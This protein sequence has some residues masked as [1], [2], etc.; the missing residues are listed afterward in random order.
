MTITIYGDFTC[1]FSYLASRRVDLLTSHGVDVEWRAVEH[2]PRTPLTGLQLSEE[3]AQ[4]M[5]EEWQS[6]ESLLLPGET[7]P[8]RAPAMLASTQAAVAAYA[9]AVGAGVS[10][11][12]RDLLF[13]AYWVDGKDI[14]HPEV[15]R[16][17]LST[18]FR[19]GTSSSHPLHEFG[20]AV[21]PA[22]GPVTSGAYHRI[23]GWRSDWAELGDATIPAMQ[24]SGVTLTGV[25]ALRR[26][27]ELIADH[28]GETVA[29]PVLELPEP[30]GRFWI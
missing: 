17:L 20:Y 26:L 6:V 14:G 1:P 9:E 21:T 3:Q 27:G 10:G 30:S 23:A 2:A 24:R 13:T 25:P 18:P 22:R 11:I 12:V 28:A 29:E 16:T 4:Q 19:L 7:L 5:K 8:G 15:L